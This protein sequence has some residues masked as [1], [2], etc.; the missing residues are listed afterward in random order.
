MDLQHFQLLQELFDSASLKNNP[1]G[2]PSQRRIPVLLP[3]SYERETERRYPLVVVLA[4]FAGSG[5]D[6]I[7]WRCWTPSFPERLDRLR[8][9]GAIGDLIVVFPDA[10]TVYGGS[11][12]LN[13]AAAGR[14]ED[15]VVKDLVDWVDSRYRTLASARHRA[16]VGKS[17]GGYGALVLGMRH[18]DVF[19]AVAC[20]SGDAYF[21]YCYARDFPRLLQQLEKHGSLEAFMEAF[22][23]APKKTSDLVL[24]MNIVAM[25]AAYSPAPEKP[26][27]VDLPFDPETGE[28]LENVWKR[29]LEQDPVRLC[30]KYADNL[31][32]LRLLFLDCG[33]RDQF[34][35]QYGLRILS[36][37]LKALGVQHSVEEFDDDHSDTSYRY[38]V[39]LPRI[40][41]AVKPDGS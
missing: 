14:Y 31:K 3:S 24:A 15:M 11:Q 38:D 9:E 5:Q 7:R 29:W 32:S 28:I 8:A 23:D 22:F 17:S 35:L 27:R 40:W 19:S 26:W 25:A 41:K 18:P 6:F 33:N 34:N 39:S 16:I 2:D 13:S 4:G 36:R 1:A 20:H 21:E 12:Y 30:T 10:F 37:R